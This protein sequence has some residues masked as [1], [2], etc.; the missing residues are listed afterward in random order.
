MI[1]RDSDTFG[2][3]SENILMTAV[4]GGSPWRN[5]MHSHRSSNQ[6]RGIALHFVTGLARL[7]CER[8]VLSKRTQPEQSSLGRNDVVG[9]MK[10]MRR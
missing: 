5:E 4:T 8:N 3:V 2:I 7:F 6:S 9:R 10:D 1:L